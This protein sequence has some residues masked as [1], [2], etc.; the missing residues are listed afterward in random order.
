MCWWNVSEINGGEEFDRVVSEREPGCLSSAEFYTQLKMK[1]NWDKVIGKLASGSS[2][3]NDNLASQNNILGSLFSG[4]SRERWKERGMRNRECSQCDQLMFSRHKSDHSSSLHLLIWDLVHKAVYCHWLVH[5]LG[6]SSTP[7]A[8]QQH[9]II[10]LFL[11]MFDEFLVCHQ[12]YR[13]PAVL[14]CLR[15]Q[16][17]QYQCRLSQ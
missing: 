4:L 10:P 6:K 2:K 15:V 8:V 9:G 13:P 3:G 17:I 1:E 16:H 11:I 7:L 12:V 14:W 5:V